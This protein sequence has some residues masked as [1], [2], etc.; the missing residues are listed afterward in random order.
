[1]AYIRKRQ[2]AKKR[3]TGVGGFIRHNTFYVRGL[4]AS[5][6]E[7]LLTI[8]P[9]LTPTAPKVAAHE[10]K[11]IIPDNLNMSHVPEPGG[12]NETI[13]SIDGNV[14]QKKR[15]V[16]VEVPM[17]KTKKLFSENP[18]ANEK[19]ERD[20]I[21][22]EKKEAEIEN[23]EI[24]KKMKGSGSDPNKNKSSFQLGLASFKAP[25]VTETSEA[26]TSNSNINTDSEDNKPDWLNQ[27]WIV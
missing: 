8:T 16:K 25:N 15:A 10:E 24:A 23:N 5:P 14:V 12:I 13:P 22:T 9:S 18:H 2:Y 11:K 4:G 17:D 6:A 21:N 1:M 20:I 27:L 7:E 19:Y 26:S 3:G